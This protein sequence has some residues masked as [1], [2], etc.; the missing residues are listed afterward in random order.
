MAPSPPC[1]LAVVPI[2][3]ELTDL[4]DAPAPI[5][6]A[7]TA[8]SSA[9]AELPIAIADVVLPVTWESLP[10]AMPLPAS[11]VVLP[12]IPDV[13]VGSVDNVN[14]SFTPELLVFWYV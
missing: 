13:G 4:E 11:Y 2:A 12:L 3:T 9:N 10:I 6:V 14:V 8:P 5:T 1:T 7:A